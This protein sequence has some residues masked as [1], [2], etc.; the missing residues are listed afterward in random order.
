MQTVT[1]S[2]DGRYPSD[3]FPVEEQVTVRTAQLDLHSGMWGGTVP[4]AARVV[5]ELVTAIIDYVIGSQITTPLFGLAVFLP[6]LAVSIRRL[7]D[8]EYPVLY[9]A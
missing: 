3:H 7:H 5:A 8:T 6:G 9:I 4:N 1:T 2:K